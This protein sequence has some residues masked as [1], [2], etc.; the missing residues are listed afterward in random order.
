M[1]YQTLDIFTDGGSRGNP[2]PAAIGVCA[3]HHQ[4]IVFQ[5]AESIGSTTNNVAEYT[6]VIKAL[7]YLLANQ[8]SVSNLNFILDSELAVKQL[9]NQYK[10]KKPH[11]LQLVNQIHQLIST[12]K[13]RQL[14]QAI[15]FS[16]VQRQQNTTADSLV[17]QALDKNP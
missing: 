10:I 13:N 8:L 17:N 7:E 2:G 15:T 5:L 16:H 14:C 11:L 9:T 3:K 4:D 6:A 1:L 12:L